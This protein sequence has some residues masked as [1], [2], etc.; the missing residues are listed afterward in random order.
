MKIKNIKGIIN[1]ELL[2]FKKDV[3]DSFDKNHLNA[4]YEFP[5]EQMKYSFNEVK[6][7]GVIYKLGNMNSLNLT[8][9]TEI[10][11]FLM[12]VVDRS[13]KYNERHKKIMFIHLFLFLKTSYITFKNMQIYL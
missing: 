11:N 7:L 12:N 9:D 4:N 10:K 5:I 3:F 1:Y 6:D 13:K 2:T 8:K